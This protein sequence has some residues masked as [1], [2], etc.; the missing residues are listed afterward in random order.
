MASFRPSLPFD[1]VSSRGEATLLY[2]NA[3]VLRHRGPSTGALSRDLTGADVANTH[4]FSQHERDV[5]EVAVRHVDAVGPVSLLLNKLPLAYLRRMVGKYCGNRCRLCDECKASL[6]N[7]G[8]GA[9][10]FD[11][12]CIRCFTD[13]TDPA[14]TVPDQLE[15]EVL[16]PPGWDAY[17]VEMESDGDDVAD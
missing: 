2:F 11:L 14:G 6:I 12:Y 9:S 16:L 17:D 4:L 1:Q 10:S 13:M 3:G 7:H 5:S 15:N 8:D